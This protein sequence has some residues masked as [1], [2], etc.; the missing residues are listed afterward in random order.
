MMPLSLIEAGDG[1]STSARVQPPHTWLDSR[2]FLQSPRPPHP[3]CWSCSCWLACRHRPPVVVRECLVDNWARER[4]AG[5]AVRCSLTEIARRTPKNGRSNRHA[6]KTL[7]P[8]HFLPIKPTHAHAHRRGGWQD[9]DSGGSIQQ[10]RPQRCCWCLCWGR[11]PSAPFPGAGSGQSGAAAAR[12]WGW[13][14]CG[15]SWMTS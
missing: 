2:P 12:A 9:E 11:R 13:A 1:A 14:G 15:D 5:W 7:T 8:P 6:A 3:V 10:P 4:L